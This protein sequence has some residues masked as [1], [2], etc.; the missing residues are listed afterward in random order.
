VRAATA[1]ATA[2]ELGL[3]WSGEESLLDPAT[4]VALGAAYLA[5]MKRDFGTWEAALAAYNLGPARL[6]DLV[7][8]G[9]PATSPYAREILARKREFDAAP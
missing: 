1:E 9:K 7:Q 5:E 6:R 8:Q 2:E 3:P 4:N